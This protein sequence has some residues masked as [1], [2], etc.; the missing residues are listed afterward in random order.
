MKK[1]RALFSSLDF[2]V[3]ITFLGDCKIT[4]REKPYSSRSSSIVH[5]PQFREADVLIWAMSKLVHIGINISSIHPCNHDN[6][7]EP[8]LPPSQM[9][10]KT[11]MLR[12][13]LKQRERTVLLEYSKRIT[14]LEYYGTVVVPLHLYHP[15]ATKIKSAGN[16]L[17]CTLPDGNLRTVL[18]TSIPGHK[19]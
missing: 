7:P 2:G 8:F 3:L 5:L 17:S 6:Y 18:C 16:L 1:P 9:T 10:G 12:P 19:K 11:A 14:V 13:K 4:C 15:Q